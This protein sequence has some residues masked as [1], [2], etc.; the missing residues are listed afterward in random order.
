MPQDGARFVPAAG[1]AVFTRL[2]DPM[3]ALTTRERVWRRRLV[4][5]V[6]A[7]LPRRG[8]VLDVGCG[9]GTLAIALAAAR[10]DATVTGVD[11]DPEALAIADGKP[12]AA[13]V[14]W[15]PGLADALPAEDDS[16]DVVVASLLFHHL[17]RPAKRAALREI[18]RVLKPGG[19]LHI[20][21]WGRPHDPVMRGAFLALQVLDGFDGTRDHAAGALPAY[22][23]E[24]GFGDPERR[25]RLRTGFGSLE[26]LRAVSPAARG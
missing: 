22:V 14:T 7:D 10:P 18:A 26:L 19:V 2:Y 6:V 17:D 9:T 15:A 25:L 4:E 3:V 8:G 21:D 20:A 1:R 24:A 5:G 12:G 11:G 16:A 13:R 23:R